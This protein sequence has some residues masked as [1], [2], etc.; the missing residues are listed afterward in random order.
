MPPSSGESD[1]ED[2]SG[3]LGGALESKSDTNA[4]PSAASR[5]ALQ[6]GDEVKFNAR[7]PENLRDAFQEV[8]EEEGRSMSWV[9][10]RWMLQAVEE[11]ET[12]L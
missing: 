2:T 5:G 4:D 11:G 1:T 7:V 3:A 10:R 12:G 6:E 8:C 9:V